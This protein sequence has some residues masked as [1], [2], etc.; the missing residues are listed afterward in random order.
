MIV[1]ILAD[2][3]AYDENLDAVIKSLLDSG[4]VKTTLLN[5]KQVL[6]HDSHDGWTCKNTSSIFKF[7]E[8]WFVLIGI[9]EDENKDLILKV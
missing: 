2:S 3:Q 4:S 7:K 8:G 9:C 6:C 1:D 5:A